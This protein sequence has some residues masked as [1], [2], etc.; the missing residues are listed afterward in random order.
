MRRYDDF[1]DEVVLSLDET[2]IPKVY[3]QWAALSAVLGALGRKC[4]VDRGAFI[5]RPNLYIVL[6][7]APANGKTAALQLPL[8]NLFRAMS[9]TPGT[10]PRDDEW[11]ELITYYE[12]DE[13]PF[14]TFKDSVTP[15]QLGVM[16]QKAHRTIPELTTVNGVFHDNSCTLITS[17]FLTFMKGGDEI[18]QALLTEMWDAGPDYEYRTKTQGEHIVRGPCLNWIAC[19]T[20]SQLVDNLPANAQDQGLLSRL[21]VVYDDAPKLPEDWDYPAPDNRKIDSFRTELGRIGHLTGPFVL[22]PGTE[23]H[24]REDIQ[25][26]LVPVPTAPALLEYSGRRISMCMKIAMGMCASR[27]NTMMIEEQDW[28]RAK[29]WLFAAEAKMPVALE[30]FGRGRAGKV[31]SD[32]EAFVKAYTYKN[33]KVHGVHENV[34]K[35]EILRRAANASEVDAMLTTMLGAGILTKDARNYYR[36]KDDSKQQ[37]ENTVQ[38]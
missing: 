35:Q 1:I 37:K 18:T 7:G 27:T 31:S 19:S 34:L 4:W 12:L 32:L 22:H 2:P 20:A 13:H 10:I 36:V 28:N 9:W 23:E 29:E 6:V 25:T 38:P 33:G 26:G 8:I 3:R 17:E 5:M 30:G 11:N 16:M 14:V 15:Q 21:L 24:V